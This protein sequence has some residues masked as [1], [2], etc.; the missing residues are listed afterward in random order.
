MK[1]PPKTPVKMPGRSAELNDLMRSWSVPSHT[2]T[3]IN[4]MAIG[5]V[6]ITDR[7]SILPIRASSMS[8]A[9]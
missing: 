3:M 6:A 5:V 4:A 1:P 2:A 7:T 9:P 8:G